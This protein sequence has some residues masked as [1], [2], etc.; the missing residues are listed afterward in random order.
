M[1]FRG[2]FE[3][4]ICMDAMEHICPEDWPTI[5]L[6]FRE[7]LKPGGLLYFTACVAELEGKTVER[8]YERAKAQG[9]PV[10]FGEV[11]DEVEEGHRLLTGYEDV[12]QIPQDVL[13]ER[14]DTA[15]Y[16][17]Y[18][19]LEQVRAWIAGAGLAI[20]EEGTGLWYEH[21]MVAR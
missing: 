20:E 12:F 18:P 13:D 9:L 10:V 5:M 14:A 15:V 21:F 7:A 11:A 8:A 2:A 19:S 16:H 4:I 17:F 6:K 3:G 1:A